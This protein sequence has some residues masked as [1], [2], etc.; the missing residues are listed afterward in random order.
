MALS[1]VTGTMIQSSPSISILATDRD[2]AVNEVVEL[3][4]SAESI[5]VQKTKLDADFEY[6]FNRATF[7]RAPTRDAALLRLTQLRSEGV[8]IRNDATKVNNATHLETW[9]RMVSDWMYEVI[10]TIKPVSR[11]DSEWFLTLDTV[12]PARVQVPIRLA[13]QA[14]ISKLQSTYNQHDFRLVRLENLLKK[15]GV[16]A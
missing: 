5:A 14:D 2:S 8:V 3:A 15:Y 11:A 7:Q 4:T 1:T 10:E 9:S 12:P 13:G 6:G 16:A